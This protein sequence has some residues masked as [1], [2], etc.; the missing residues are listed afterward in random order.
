MANGFFSYSKENKTSGGGAFAFYIILDDDYKAKAKEFL[1]FIH[2]KLGV[3]IFVISDCKGD[4]DREFI[5]NNS[6]N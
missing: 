6:D 4:E 5:K 1:Q 3:H 2:A